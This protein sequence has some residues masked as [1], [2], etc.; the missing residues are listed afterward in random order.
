MM[1]D[2]ANEWEQGRGRASSISEE[3]K[4][5]RKELVERLVHFPESATVRSND[6]GGTGRQTPFRA[7]I[8]NY[9]ACIGTHFPITASDPLPETEWKLR[10]GQKFRRVVLRLG[11][12]IND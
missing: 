11:S 10:R 12:E 4:R 6:F 8:V 1:T 9:F 2:S 7:S 5:I 3:Q